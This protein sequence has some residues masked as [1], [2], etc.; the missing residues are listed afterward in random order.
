MR[1][2]S[3]YRRKALEAA[4][5]V[6]VDASRPQV[7]TLLSAKASGGTPSAPHPAAQGHPSAATTRRP[8]AA[9]DE[10]CCRNHCLNRTRNSR[11][12]DGHRYMHAQITMFHGFPRS[13][14]HIHTYQALSGV[15]GSRAAKLFHAH[16]AF[17]GQIVRS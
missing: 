2:S 8:A 7:D 13:P 3:C 14:T 5:R 11:E 16:V 12:H 1:A 15:L 9:D 4:L 10:I 6:M 17:S